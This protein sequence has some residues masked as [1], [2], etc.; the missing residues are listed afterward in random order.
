MLR[1][2]LSVFV[3]AALAQDA[4]CDAATGRCK[5]APGE[6]HGG[7]LVDLNL[8][9]AAAAKLVAGATAT[10][11]L[12]QRQACDVSL[13]INGG[14]SPLTGFMKQADY[15]SVVEGMRLTSGHLFGLPV[16]LDVPD[17]SLRGKTVLL[18]YQGAKLAVFEAEEVWKPDKVKEAKASYGTTSTEHPSVA[19]LFADLGKFYAGGKLHGLGAGFETVWG[20]GFRTPKE[21]RASLPAGKQVVAFQNRNP[22][23]KAHFE[24]LVHAN[25]DVE[26]SIVLVHPTCGPTQPGDIDGPTRIKTYEVLQEEPEYKKWA[27]ESFRWSYLPYSMKMAGPR[28]AIQHMIIRKNFGATHFIIGRDMAGTKSTLTSEDFYGAYEAQ[29]MGKKH[30]EELSV[31]VVDYPNMVYVGQEHGNERGY[32]TDVEAKAKGVKINKLSGTEFRKRLRSGEEI[33]EW[34]A[35]P[36]VVK[37]L[38]EGG[39]KIFLWSFRVLLIYFV[40]QPAEAPNGAD[41]QEQRQNSSW[42]AGQ[43]G[44]VCGARLRSVLHSVEG[45]ARLLFSTVLLCWNIRR[46]LPDSEGGNNTRLSFQ[47]W[48]EVN[49]RIEAD[50]TTPSV[51]VQ[52]CIY[53]TLLQDEQRCIELL[54]DASVKKTAMPE[55]QEGW[56]SIPPGGLERF[57]V[58][59]PH[60]HQGGLSGAKLSHC[61]LSETSSSFLDRGHKNGINLLQPEVTASS[62]EAVWMSLKY[63]FWLFFSTSPDDPA[64]YVFIRLQDTVLRETNLRD[65]SLVLAGRMKKSADDDVAGPFGDSAREPLRLCFLLADGRFQLFE[66]L[67]LELQLTSEEA[68]TALVRCELSGFCRCLFGS[69][70]WRQQS[71]GELSPWH[72]AKV[73]GKMRRTS[74]RTLEDHT[75]E[76]QSPTTLQSCGA[77]RM[78]NGAASAAKAKALAG[79]S[80]DPSKGVSSASTSSQAEVPAAADHPVEVGHIGNVATFP[81]E[82]SGTSVDGPATMR[83]REK[84]SRISAVPEQ[85]GQ[86]TELSEALK[87]PV[88]GRRASQTV[89]PEMLDPQL[90]EFLTKA[91]QKHFLL[92]SVPE[93]ECKA[94]SLSMKVKHAVPEEVV[95]RQGEIVESVYFIRYG[96]FQMMQDNACLSNVLGPG[97]SFGEL[98]LLY[99][100]PSSTTIVATEN[101]E[102]W[103]MERQRFLE[104]KEQLS[105]SQIEKAME[106]FQACQ[107]FRYLKEDD[108]KSLAAVCTSKTFEDGSIVLQDEEV[109]ECMLIV[110]SGQVAAAESTADAFDRVSYGKPGSVIGSVGV[111]YHKQQAK[112][113]AKG[114]VEC[115]CLNKAALSGFSPSVL[116]VLRRAAFKAILHSLPRNPLDPEPWRILSEQQVNLLI[117]RT[118]DGTFEP[119]EIIF[120]PQDGAQLIVVISGQVAIMKG[121]AKTREEDELVFAGEDVDILQQSD[122]VIEAG[123]C[124]GKQPEFLEGVSM[125]TF[126]I[127]VGKVRLHR[128]LHSNVQELLGDSLMEVMRCA[129]I[130]RVLSDIFL[131]KNLNEEQIDRTVRELEQQIFAAGEIIV[132]QDDP[133]R[134]FYLIQRGTVVVRKDGKVL[135]TLGRWDYFGE[136]GLLLQERRSATCQALDECICLVLDADEFFQIVGHFKD[137]LERRMQLQDLNLSISDLQ[138]TAVVGRG[139]FGVVRLVTPKGKKDAPEYALKCVK[140]AQVVKGHQQ[141][142]IIMEREVNAQ[143][144]HPCIV[145]FIKTFQDKYNVYFLTE[146]LGG[147]DLFYAIRAIGALTKVQSQF[148]TGSIAL[149]IEYLHGRGIMY[150]DLKPENVLLDFAGRAKLVDFGCCKKEIRA[151]TLVG[152][153]E[154]LAPEVIKGKGYTKSIDWW[155]LGVMLY[156]FVVGPIPFGAGEEDQMRLFAAISEAPLTF[157]TYVAED[158]MQVLSGLLERRPERRLGSSGAKEIKKHLWF[159]GFDWD[160]LAGGFFPPPWQPDAQ[161]QMR[162]W[163]EPD[164]DLMDHVSTESFS[165]AK[166]MEWAKLF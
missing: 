55:F 68:F 122:K 93:V 105:S 118:E 158:A 161:A 32:A 17:E 26:N 25:K 76:P 21:V 165:F 22:V 83:R 109:G 82:A 111:L 64:P 66:A 138:C 11:E 119:G 101:G 129:E 16:I 10:L 157:P 112:S 33:P 9:D 42:L 116:D 95:V 151:N 40:Q 94:L 137:E 156:E 65:K 133:A 37:V 114:P 108:Q 54:P 100:I 160:A 34:F 81:S 58:P 71:E 72:E 15:N 62:G 3:S 43:E 13:L 92:K 153:P 69:Y 77:T 135:R 141:K 20:K 73:Q 104:C 84:R 67:W 97:D 149:G 36:K 87:T 166:G 48:L 103:K 18:T 140:K 23:H 121:L 145:Q 123:H 164:G 8:A 131:F 56:A 1:L 86:S 30:S 53:N 31:K 51:A 88:L 63:A 6:P 49:S 12:S 148:F 91:F 142:A 132:Q 113:F 139:T 134:H 110:I 60:G 106:F 44:E 102:L 80:S 98:A 144:Y 96:S 117:S 143:C 4:T 29:D 107:D 152:T 127:A 128:I 90:E 50:G 147:G 45:L 35:F 85:A 38:R 19:E 78:G 61:V 24:L 99:S 159:K 59:M 150:R 130:K 46:V 89:K 5:S 115:L 126:G 125:S 154:Y 27:G 74:Q 79:A 75:S 70:A 14:F 136:R 41:G 162:N 155:S 163:E 120:A 146:F 28:E 124:Y 47:E 57:D 7:S 39:D 52:K 2:I